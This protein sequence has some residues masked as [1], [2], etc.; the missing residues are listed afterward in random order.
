MSGKAAQASPYSGTYCTKLQR[1]PK[2]AHVH[3]GTGGFN[4]EGKCR[5]AKTI[6]SHDAEPIIAPEFGQRLD[7]LLLAR[8]TDENHRTYRTDDGFSAIRVT[9]CRDPQCPDLTRARNR[10][11]RRASRRDLS[12]GKEGGV[13]VGRFCSVKPNDP[14]GKPM[15]FYKS[16]VAF[17][18][19]KIPLARPADLSASRYA[20]RPKPTNNPAGLP[21]GSFGFS[22]FAFFV[23]RQPIARLHPGA[24]LAVRSDQTNSADFRSGNCG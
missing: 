4:S 1:H 22:L 7:G 21:S 12:A 11:I 14:R 17:E 18:H 23:S 20:E 10:K 3:E 19:H 24:I 2:R 5:S 13:C 8:L 6:S 15:G 16:A 9:P